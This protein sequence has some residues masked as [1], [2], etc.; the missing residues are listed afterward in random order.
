MAAKALGDIMKLD[1]KYRILH[2]CQGL[3]CSAA[4]G[5]NAFYL[6]EYGF[7]AS[8]IGIIVALFGVLTA[9]CLPIFGRIADKSRRF[10]WKVL[11]ALFCAFGILDWGLL[12]FCK[13]K[14]VVGI[15]F[16]L[17]GL[18]M[19]CILPMMN[20][21]CFYYE[22][23]GIYVNY[24][25]A[26]G[27]NSL[28]YAVCSFVLGR[29][30]VHFGTTAITAV[31]FLVSVFTLL[32]TISM[33]YVKSAEDADAANRRAAN[34]NTADQR[35]ANENT[36]DRI[37]ANANAADQNTAV[38][39]VKIQ[40]Q[41]KAEKKFW[42]KYPAFMVMV[43]GSVFLMA[44]FSLT[45][46]FLINVIE[47]VGGS[48][49]HLGTA[50]AISALAEVPVLMLFSHIVKRIP[51]TKL[52]IIAGIAY[53]MKCLM[54]FCAGNIQMVYVAQLLQ[55]FSY[56]IYAS[57]SV[58]FSDKCME[59][60]DAVTGQTLVSMSGSAGSVIGSLVGGYIVETA[61]V[62]MML[63]GG[64]V[65]AVATVGVFW[66]AAWMYRRERALQME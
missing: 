33:P 17:T 7:H 57:A 54:L 51:E 24:G 41:K 43:I 22:K 28:V 52:L 47:A 53:A 11:L 26:R 39:D 61:G 10:N 4:F 62:H 5:Y 50:L 63:A 20:V 13:S 2:S 29:L 25:I 46:T 48:S 66:I 15:L 9:I 18:V 1:G 65:T 14:L 12:F 8:E 55:M 45:T 44:T 27:L 23:R 16:Q 6:S 60:E 64:M 58:Y 34:A 40:A 30:T 35:A 21:A 37:A 38:R 19:S 42:K 32:T 3:L 49:Q 36:A 56:A 59:E 31:G